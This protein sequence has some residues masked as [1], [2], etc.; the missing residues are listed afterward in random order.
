MILLGSISIIVIAIVVILYKVLSG[1]YT[2]VLTN[3]Y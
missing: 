1:V 2:L 3:K